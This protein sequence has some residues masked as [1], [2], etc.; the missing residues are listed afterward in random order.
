[1]TQSLNTPFV[2]TTDQEEMK[3][4]QPNAHA[5]VSEIEKLSCGNSDNLNYDDLYEDT[6]TYKCSRL[7]Q[8]FDR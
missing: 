3:L 1:M 7:P 6:N 4:N 5:I 8:V 2:E